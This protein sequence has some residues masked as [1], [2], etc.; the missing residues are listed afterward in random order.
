MPHIFFERLEQRKNTQSLWSMNFLGNVNY[1]S[2]SYSSLANGSQYNSASQFLSGNSSGNWMSSQYQSSGSFGSTTTTMYCYAMGPISKPIEGQYYKPGKPA[3]IYT[4][5]ELS[6]SM[7]NS[8]SLF[9]E[10]IA[11]LYPNLWD[12]RTQSILGNKTWDT[13]NS[14]NIFGAGSYG[15][16][17]NQMS[18]LSTQFPQYPSNLGNWTSPTYSLSPYQGITGP[19]SNYGL[20]QFPTFQGSSYINNNL[21]IM[22]NSWGGLSPLTKLQGLFKNLVAFFQ[23]RGILKHDQGQNLLASTLDK[24]DKA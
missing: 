24:V 2:S 3:P 18:P 19:T 1:G 16:Q 13:F 9:P 6:L 11:P 23:N 22:N 7:H 17:L 8:S 12:I 14:W 4:Q 15:S 5:P 20:P 10:T 21:N